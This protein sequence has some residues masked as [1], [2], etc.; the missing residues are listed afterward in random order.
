MHIDLF[1]S[2]NSNFNPQKWPHGNETRETR[3]CPAAVRLYGRL[4]YLWLMSSRCSE[5]L[6]RW[7]A[8][9]QMARP[10]AGCCWKVEES[11]FSLTRLTADRSCFMSP[12]HQRGR[13]A[14]LPVR[15]VAC[16]TWSVELGAGGTLFLS[17][18]LSPQ[19]K[20]VKPEAKHLWRMAG[21]WPSLSGCGM[22]EVAGRGGGV[23]LR[24][25][26]R[27][28]RGHHLCFL[29]AM[30]SAHVSPDAG[31]TQDFS[32]Q[33]A[34][35]SGGPDHPPPTSY[36]T[37]HLPNPLP[38]PIPHSSNATLLLSAVCCHFSRSDLLPFHSFLYLFYS[39]P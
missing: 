8:G 16:C 11:S 22:V 4:L 5:L 31:N 7:T 34:G 35:L 26:W 30:C 3:L 1:K 24:G 14:G 9:H 39:L 36:I 2:F 21:L 15:T 23:V 28:F 12:L 25:A 38:P 18:S 10:A 27:G 32:K 6:W 17:S 19:W 13:L 29:W 20:N 33:A 37:K